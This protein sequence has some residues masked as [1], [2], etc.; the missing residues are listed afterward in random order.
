MNDTTFHLQNVNVKTSTVLLER[1]KLLQEK[2]NTEIT[3]KNFVE[4]YVSKVDKSHKNQ[5][6]TSDE[7]SGIEY[8]YM[9]MILLTREG[10]V[11]SNFIQLV[12]LACKRDPAS[13]LLQEVSKIA[14]KYENKAPT[15]NELCSDVV[16]RPRSDSCTSR[17]SGTWSDS[18][19]MSDTKSSEVNSEEDEDEDE[20]EEEE[21]ETNEGD[22]EDKDGYSSVAFRNT[23]RRAHDRLRLGLFLT[24]EQLQKI[25]DAL[26][27]NVCYGTER[28]EEKQKLHD[29]MV[30]SFDDG[31]AIRQ[32]ERKILLLGP[33]LPRSVTMHAQRCSDTAIRQV[34]IVD[35]SQ[36][37]LQK[38]LKNL[39]DSRNKLSKRIFVSD[40]TS[41]KYCMEEP[42][43]AGDRK[44]DYTTCIF[45]LHHMSSHDRQ[46]IFQFVRNSSN[47]LHVIFF[48]SDDD[49]DDNVSNINEATSTNVSNNNN[50]SPTTSKSTSSTSP[51]SPINLSSWCHPTSFTSLVDSFE[52]G[53]REAENA[54]ADDLSKENTSNDDSTLTKEGTLSKLGKCARD[55][56]AQHFI[57]ALTNNSI[58]TTTIPT[59]FASSP[60]S[61][62]GKTSDGLEIGSSRKKE[63]RGILQPLKLSAVIK[64]MENQGLSILS[65]KC[66]QFSVSFL[67][68][69]LTKNIYFILLLLCNSNKI[70]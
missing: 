17:S 47:M 51:N 61:K 56:L 42:S 40:S 57:L 33:T 58:S 15:L 53:M 23:I 55:L 5:Q 8:F 7:T 19:K 43:W 6:D 39:L 38:I 44:Y 1:L 11:T 70:I 14:Q 26:H 63:K 25:D 12:K 16:R 34:H 31:R 45:S 69:L 27:A 65:C 13:I 60:D 49:G 32:K 66:F 35:W 18:P 64:E 54:F 59:T 9:A 29:L 24:S 50:N 10:Y 62:S 41:P 3:A 67:S 46:G 4:E 21:D 28:E 36:R 30:S 20:E 22:S 48:N 68:S 37:R 52:Q 2:M